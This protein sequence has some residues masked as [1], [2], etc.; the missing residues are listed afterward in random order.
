MADNIEKVERR[1]NA[2][3]SRSTQ[4]ALI[5]AARRLFEEQG[6]AETSTEQI[7]NEAGV[8]RGALYHH[9]RDKKDLFRAVLEAIQLEFAREAGR[10][11]NVGGDFWERFTAVGL[12]FFEH[13]SQKSARL[14]FVDGLAVLGYRQWR[15]LD[16][17]VHLPSLIRTI[18]QAIEEGTL[19][20]Q[21][22]ELLA[23]MLIALVNA[24]GIMLVESDDIALADVRPLWQRVVAGLAGRA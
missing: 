5:D 6:Y 12:D 21:N 18:D 7:V 22:T 17:T 1:S 15:E 13:A 11:W 19:P 14:L 8:T 23:R 2:E 24:L 9:Y 20:E 10:S 16:E 4:A 3:R